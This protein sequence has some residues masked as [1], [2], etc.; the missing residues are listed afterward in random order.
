MHSGATCMLLLALPTHS[1]YILAILTFCSCLVTDSLR[2][3]AQ[4]R[5]DYDGHVWVQ[6]RAG[7]WWEVRV[8]AQVPGTV[9]L[10]DPRGYVHF[11]SLN[12]QQVGSV[13][14]LF[15]AL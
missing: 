15:S 13:H 3:E 14:A 11:I 5:R 7:E 9:L 8:D 2:Q 12:L 10:R 4:F 6:S 1:Y